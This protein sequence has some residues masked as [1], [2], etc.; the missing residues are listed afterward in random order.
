MRCEELRDLLD[1]HVD[2]ELPEEVTRKLE[3]HL[4]RCPACAYEARTL[5]QTGAMLRETVLPAETSPAFRE[6]MAARLR[7]AFV[8]HLRP[9]PAIETGCQWELPF[10]REG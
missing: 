3:R 1:L 7:N 8:G 2:G 5:E 10:A 6:R 9:T 4:L